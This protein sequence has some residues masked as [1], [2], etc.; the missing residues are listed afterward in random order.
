MRLRGRSV[1]VRIDGV[2]IGGR[3][4]TVGIEV[5]RRGCC[6]VDGGD[7]GKIVLEFIEV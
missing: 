7:D 1:L 3:V 5:F 6:G 4:G 2:L